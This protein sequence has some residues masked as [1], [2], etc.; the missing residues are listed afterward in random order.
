MERFEETKKREV[1]DENDT[2]DENIAEGVV[3]KWLVFF[4]EKPEQ[5]RKFRSE[6]L[7]E[8]NNE[9]EAR[10]RQHNQLII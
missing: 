4:W 9:S 7:Q 10:K 8:E 3:Q 2:G 5:D 6:N 1:Q